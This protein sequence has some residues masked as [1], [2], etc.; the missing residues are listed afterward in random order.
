M[1][2]FDAFAKEYEALLSKNIRVTGYNPAYFDELKIKEV[3]RILKKKKIESPLKIL[4]FGC[5][6]GKHDRLF[7]R[8]FPSCIIYGIDVSTS[9]LD[10]ARKHNADLDNCNYMVYSGEGKF[11]IPE[12]VDLIFIANVLHHIPHAAHPAILAECQ[13]CL[14]PKGHLFI[15]EH[16]PLNPLTRYA[17]ATCEF[18]HDAV[19]LPPLYTRR[20]LKEVGFKKRFCRFLIF[21]PKFLSFLLFLEAYLAWLPLGGQY[22]YVGYKSK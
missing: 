19:L 12:D 15:F 3:S 14:N 1:S 18:D 17:V 22:L 16:N 7:K 5:G 6:I 11:P 9:S 20:L 4:N 2:E 13:R 10:E 21:F 8:Y